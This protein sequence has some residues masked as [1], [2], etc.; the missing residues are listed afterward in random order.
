[1]ALSNLDR[2]G[3]ALDILAQGLE[4]FVAAALA[5][6]V[7]PGKD[8]TIILAAKDAQN[9]AAKQYNRLDPNDQLRAL[10]EKL[11]PGW[12]PFD[13]KLS[14]AEQNLA[15][16]ARDIRN[17]WAHRTP[18]NFDDAYRALDTLERLLR[19]AGYPVGADQIRSS[20]ED[21]RNSN[22]QKDV[23]KAT[24]SGVLTETGSS[25]IKAW[26]D[27]VKPH[28]DVING[29]FNAS[30][31]AADLHMVAQ[32]VG[33]D[34]YID[35]VQFFRR[36]YLT[37]GLKDLLE[38]AVCRISGDLNAPPVINLQTNFGGG[39]THSMLAL[40][41]IMSGHELGEYPQE[42]QELL[43]GTDL[44]AF[45]T[46]RRAVLVGN[47]IA[48]T[49]GKDSAKSDGTVVNTLWGE[50]AWQLGGREGYDIVKESDVSGT[51]PGASLRTLLSQHS[52]SR[53]LIDEWVAYARQLYARDGLPA[54]TF[55]TQFTFAQTLTEAAK[56][57]PGVM[58]V[59][60]IPASDHTSEGQQ[61]SSS[62]LEV[63]GANGK[64]ALER[65]QNVVR[66]VAD[67]WR[68]ATSRE[69]FEIVRRRLFEAPSGD[70]SVDIS[71]TA[72]QFAEF[73]KNHR[74]EFPIETM[75][76]EYERRI[77]EAYPI[78]PE[79]FER[80]YRD[81]STL[82][83]FQRT[84][85]VLRLMSTVV[86]ELWM[87]G[88]QSP[89]IMPGS[90]PLDTDGVLT[91]ITQYLD[92][93]WKPIIDAD[94]DGSAATPARIDASR[95]AFQQRLLSRR[96]A[97]TIFLGSAP[98]LRSAHKG[99]ERQHVA[100]GVAIPGDVVGNFGSALQLMSE[101]ATYFY[102]ESSRYWFDV[103]AS[104]SRKA[105]DIAE[106]LHKEDVWQ[107]I[108]DRLNK[109]EGRATSAFT[110]TVVAPSSSSDVPDVEGVRLVLLHPK[111]R[112]RSKAET[113]D[114]LA[115]AHDVYEHRGSANRQHR[116]TV[117]FLAPDENEYVSLDTAVRDFIAWRDINGQIDDLGLTR[118]QETQVKARLAESRKAVDLRLSGTYLWAL[119][120]EIH[121]G[122]AV[123]WSKQKIGSGSESLTERTGAALVRYDALR[124]VNAPAAIKQALD[125]RLRAR[126]NDGRIAVG[127]LW[128]Y[129]TQ[130]A[131][132]R[133]IRDRSVLETGVRAVLDLPTWSTEGF[134][135]AE[136]YDEASGDFLGLALPMTNDSFGTITDSTLLVDPRLAEKQREREAATA[137]TTIE[138]PVENVS[139]GSGGRDGVSVGLPWERLEP[140]R[141]DRAKNVRFTGTFYA[142]AEALRAD[143]QKVYEE[144]L[145]HLATVPDADIEVSVDVIANRAAGFDADTVRV[146][147]E[148]AMQLKFE[149]AKFEDES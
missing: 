36:T 54:G 7:P 140:T 48:V 39:K 105:K 131:Y 21:L 49:P 30:E 53:I 41:H 112:Q 20:R 15:G 108:V 145:S 68:P 62:D 9:G 120:P 82:E 97:R 25:T 72:R 27:V 119:A 28:A 6:K 95:P 34:E 138:E 85:G 69:S 32:G 46:C 135:L 146:V 24:T 86:H 31:F 59:V 70:A 75:D 109:V 117:V 60:S 66:R 147:R 2:I 99:I 8:W 84:R 12:F 56:S 47:H 4:P 5:S 121:E 89:M 93:Q 11:I 40:W 44:R 134:A 102:S 29:T 3:K 19:V 87:A 37:E 80:L 133:R 104:V 43:N 118:Q 77:A 139:E 130:Y 51:N 122:H 132:L 142:R 13:G 110:G 127:E 74:D 115:F 101:Q 67:Q 57:V 83:R 55:D 23:K 143:L 10:T 38:K 1:M 137:R 111:H 148:N 149:S 123:Q 144:V 96:L 92:D 71:S 14:R 61:N 136:G 63:G 98:T 126:W 90:V 129:Y 42:I 33:S 116:N 16:E 114:A 141:R 125:G 65:L 18:V 100:L 94:V 113:S 58:L 76:R 26:R 106:R 52:P 73:Y 124:V 79:L 22:F 45:G 103:Q 91:E 78:H 35:P 107:E 64:A 128:G 81:W 17:N 88:D 50:L